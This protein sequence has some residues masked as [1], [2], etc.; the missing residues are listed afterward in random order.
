MFRI[1]LRHSLMKS[2][3]LEGKTDIHCHVLPGVDDGSPD[4]EHSLELLQFM[5]Q[6][7]EFRRLWLT[8][9]VMQDLGNT[10]E[11]LSWT[12]A[13]FKKHYKGPIQLQLA[14]EYMLDAGFS[15]RL[16]TD[17]LPLGEKRLLVETSYMS[18]PPDFYDILLAVWRKGYKP[19]IAHPE[20]YMYMEIDDYELLKSK[21]YE[22]QLNLMSL[23]GYY[24]PRPKLVAEDL[25]ERG[26]YDMV[27]SDLHHLHRYADMFRHLKLTRRQID[28]VEQ[29]YANNEQI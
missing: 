29:L 8:P 1:R 12:F 18:A 14:S 5:E 11:R 4:V 23:S 13:S 24:G 21:G 10:A 9:H 19:L 20:R 16:I 2:G 17:P 26:M 7:M 27:G 6:T 28:A 22:F 15:E 3:I 25:L